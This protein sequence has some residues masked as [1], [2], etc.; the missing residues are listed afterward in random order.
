MNIIKK[1]AVI[2]FLALSIGPG[3]V[4]AYAEEA[5]NSPAASS[6]SETI[7]H[8][9]KALVEIA[10]SDF[11]AAQVHLKAARASGEKITG[12]EAIVKKANAIVIQGQI[13]TKLGDIKSSSEELN[14]ALELYKSL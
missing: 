6:V 8:I 11:N 5:V 3:S 4:T 13:K 7:S 1:I 2:L 14:K 12:N 10:K 9:E